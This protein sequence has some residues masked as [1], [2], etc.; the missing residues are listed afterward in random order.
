[1]AKLIFWKSKTLCGACEGPLTGSELRAGRC[2][3][4][5]EEAALVK[6]GESAGEL[7]DTAAHALAKSRGGLSYDEAL[8]AVVRAKPE[9]WAQ[10]MNEMAAAGAPWNGRPSDD[11]A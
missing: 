7:L 1:V 11:A 2:S 6:G 5:G 9:L 8:S 4:C 3:A 10:H